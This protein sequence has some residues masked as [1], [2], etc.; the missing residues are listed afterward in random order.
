MDDLGDVPRPRGHEA[1]PPRMEEA[2]AERARQARRGARRHDFRGARGQPGHL[3]RPEGVPGAQEGGRAHL[4]QAR[5]AH[6]ARERLGRA[7]AV[8]RPRPGEARLQRG[9]AGQAVVRGHHLREDSP[10]MALP[11]RRDGRVVEDDRRLVDVGEHGGRARRRRAQDGHS[12]QEARQGLRA[13]QRPRE[14]ARLA[15][16]RQDDARGRHQAVDGLDR[17]PVG[18]RGDG[19]AHGR[20]QGRVRA[21]AHLREPRAGGARDLRVHRVLLQQGKDPLGAGIPQPRGV[22]AGQ[23]A[24]GRSPPE[25]GVGV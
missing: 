6:H 15:P 13:P 12:A 9:R 1:G 3:R 7:A 21:R 16:D 4:P 25:G 22:R 8:R 23:P 10:G 14:P 19:V 11:G 17:E 2:A 5:G 24:R 18:Q 20:H